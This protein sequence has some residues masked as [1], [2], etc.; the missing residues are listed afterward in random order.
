MRY[1]RKVGSFRAV[2]QIIKDHKA[3]H[4]CNESFKTP[5]SWLNITHSRHL[6]ELKQSRVATV[7]TDLET[8]KWGA[9]W[10]ASQSS[11]ESSSQALNVPCMGVKGTYH[12]FSGG[13]KFFPFSTCSSIYQ[14]S[15]PTNIRLQVVWTWSKDICACIKSRTDRRTWILLLHCLDLY[16]EVPL[17]CT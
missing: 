8:D 12:L 9:L 11:C 3:R 13:S 7:S 4:P 15:S 14:P 10:D 17:L 16:L 1:T 6:E 2:A 5:G